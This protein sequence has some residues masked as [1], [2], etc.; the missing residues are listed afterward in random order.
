MP[1]GALCWGYGAVPDPV[2]E[3]F[4]EP[5]CMDLAMSCL[6]TAL[7]ACR[8]HNNWWKVGENK[9][10]R[11]SKGMVTNRP[12]TELIEV[13]ESSS[14]EVRRAGRHET[15]EA[16]F[17]AKARRDPPPIQYI[18]SL[19]TAAGIRMR[20]ASCLGPFL[21]ILSPLHKRAPCRRRVLATGLRC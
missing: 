19:Y 8:R 6:A 18:Y 20:R 3:A 9:W 16:H 1:T 2:Q 17:P 13:V 7:V 4:R 14:S 11:W 15:S 5:R 12:S 21:T 10:R